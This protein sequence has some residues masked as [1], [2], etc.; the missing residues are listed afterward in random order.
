MKK[1]AAIMPALLLSAMMFAQPTVSDPNVQVRKR[2]IFMPSAYP[3]L[4]MF[5]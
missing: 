1:I 3:A 2:R 5:T 4:L